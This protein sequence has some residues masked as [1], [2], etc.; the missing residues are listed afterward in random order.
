ESVYTQISR[1][2][3]TTENVVAGVRRV[4]VPATFGVL[5]TMAAFLPML[6]IEG[7]GEPFFTSLSVVV[8]LCLIFS[9]VES[10]MI[11]PAHLAHMQKLK[12]GVKS[13]NP[14]AKVQDAFAGWLDRFIH[15]RYQPFLERCIRNRYVTMSVF[16]GAMMILIGVCMSPL[17]RFAFFPNVPSEFIRLNLTMHTGTSIAQRNEA[18]TRV[19]QAMFTL[20]QEY[21]LA[22]DDT[23]L[24]ESMMVW[25]RGDTEGGGFV[26][27][28]KAETRTIGPVEVKDRWRELTGDVPGVKLLNFSSG[29]HAGGSK[30]VY[31]R[32]SSTDNE[33]LKLAAGELEA[34]LNSY[35]GLFEVESTAESASD[36]VILDIR[37]AAQ[38]LGLS[39]AEL[40]NQIRQGF[41]GEE[42]QKIQRGREEVKVMLR[43]PRDERN[44][45]TDLEK[46]RIRAA[47]GSEIPFYQVATIEEG[48]GTSY[49]RRTNGKRSMAVSAD[50]DKDTIEQGTV[51][52]DVQA[53]FLPGLYD[54]YPNVSV[55]LG[56]A[57][58]DQKETI[59]QMVQLTIMGLLLIYALIAIPLKSYMQPLIIMSIIPFGLVG[60]VVGH[61]LLGLSI[62]MM[63]IFGLIA[64]AGVLVNDSLILVDF[65]NKGRDEGLTLS[66]AS[67][68]AGKE[69]FRA[70]ILTSLTTFLGLVPITLETSAQAQFVIPMAV[71]LGF[72]ILFATA[73]TL[74]LIP[75]LCL[76]AD[77]VKALLRWLWTGS[78]QS[79]NLIEGVAA[80]PGK[81]K[82][83]TQ[84]ETLGA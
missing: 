35:E 52:K 29:E 13:T 61:L 26:E 39:L 46:V 68:S 77:D 33:Q 63:S 28:T 19:E 8:I 57:S 45:L 43:Y 31:F 3:H 70:I 64:L 15:Q 76:V 65:I 79:V 50:L 42:V 24:F 17:V 4:V 49:I 18:L 21:R 71:S 73:I 69:R 53:N 59:L 82:I 22:H 44:D 60:A 75:V 38:A 80:E 47:D 16:L 6:F 81:T 7:S 37:P 1:Y 51:I 36:E 30:P 67:V 34:Y 66:E 41:Y 84:K 12:P 9:L 2:G 83:E 11:L 55:G 5:T 32:L 20:D 56:G 74:V 78:R 48:V 58:L 72:G 54:R 27:L 25:S 14:L 10:K 40:G 23:K 62:S